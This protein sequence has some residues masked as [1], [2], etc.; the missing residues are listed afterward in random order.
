MPPCVCLT[1]KRASAPPSAKVLRRPIVAS[2]LTKKRWTFA[3]S[4]CCDR[5]LCVSGGRLPSARLAASQRLPQ[6]A[7]SPLSAATKQKLY[8]TIRSLKQ[9]PRRGRP[10]SEEGTREILFRLYPIL[11]ITAC[12]LR[13]RV[14]HGAAPVSMSG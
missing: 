2:S 14:G 12:L 5:R 7:L 4:R 1:T 13:F 6:R 9:G 11:Q 3:S 10:G 8:E